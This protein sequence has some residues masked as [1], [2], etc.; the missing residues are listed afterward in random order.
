MP[1][2]VRLF[3]MKAKSSKE[4]SAMIG[5]AADHGYRKGSS[6]TSQ[7][8]ARKVEGFGE[9]IAID[10]SLKGVSGREPGCGC[11]VQLDL[12]EEEPWHAYLR[13]D[14]GGGGGTE[15]VHTEQSYGLSR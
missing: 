13:Y 5:T 6:D 7:D 3:E 8:W 9:H 10:G 15:N 11:A 14:A 12:N 1:D 2:V 4:S